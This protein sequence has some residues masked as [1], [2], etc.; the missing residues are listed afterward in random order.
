MLYR[1][2]CLVVLLM[3]AGCRKSGHDR[4]LDN[5]KPVAQVGEKLLYHSEVAD[6]VPKGA[7]AT[8]S[9]LLVSR[10]VD[11]WV[12]KQLL[13]DR[14]AKEVKVDNEEIE[15]KMQ[16]YRNALLMYEFEKQYVKQHLDSIVTN[17]EMQTYYGQNLANFTLKQNIVQGKMLALPK[18]APKQDR[19]KALFRSDKEPDRRELTSYCYRFAQAYQ[20]DDTLWV[21]LETLINN[22][23]YR[24][25]ANKAQFLQ[26]DYFAET[27]DGQNGYWLFI[28]DFKP[29]N[30]AAPFSF[31]KD[32]IRGV[33]L[34]KRRLALMQNLEK[35][36]YEE[37]R[38]AN[39]F[40]MYTA[41]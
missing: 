15:Q 24:E 37:A 7:S 29:A 26:K 14:A 35:K 17:Q 2:L 30:Q 21:T 32:Q 5:E 38:S 19:A 1:I 41:K 34:T 11:G 18:D 16:E 36:I 8:D 6:M 20:L 10:Y 4:E 9:T 33:I 3:A 40:K 22:T 23:P 31:V 12:R 27:S 13:L 25:T 39:K 28:R